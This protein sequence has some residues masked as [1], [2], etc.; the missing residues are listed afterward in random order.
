MFLKTLGNSKFNYTSYFQ[1]SLNFFWSNAVQK[2]CPLIHLEF[3][4]QET[5]FGDI[6]S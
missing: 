6:W 1:K 3:R 2:L 5:D 4:C